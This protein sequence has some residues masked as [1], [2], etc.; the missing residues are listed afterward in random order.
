MECLFQTFCKLNFI[1]K[2]LMNNTKSRHKNSCFVL[3]KIPKDDIKFYSSHNFHYDA[4]YSYECY[5]D[6]D[7]LKIG[8]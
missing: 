5:S 7:M 6:S 1:K 2:M 4:W 3:S 8:L